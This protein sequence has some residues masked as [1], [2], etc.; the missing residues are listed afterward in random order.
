MNNQTSA[1][2]W[3]G[4]YRAETARWER[5]GLHPAFLAWRQQG[6]LPACRVLIPC[7]GRSPEPLAMAEGG[8]DVTVV[9]LAPSAVA[10]QRAR[11]ADRDLPARIVQ[12]NLFAWEPDRPFD[13]VYDQ[14][15][16]C[17]LPPETWPAY[18]MRLRRWVVPGGRLLVLFMQT[19][20]EGGPPFHCD[21]ARMR[22]LFSPAYWEWPERL[23]DPVAHPSGLTEQPAVLIRL[24]AP[25][26]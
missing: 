14:T 8:S 22:M 4:R 26:A 11:F 2:D 1:T 20:R 6:S 7:A 24:P 9:D 3:E 19:G 15:A 5:A 16:L 10:T 13:A 23:P 21:M 17:A 25:L 18:E 12:A